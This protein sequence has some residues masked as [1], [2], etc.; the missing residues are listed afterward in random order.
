LQPLDRSNRQGVEVLDLGGHGFVLPR[1][2]RKPVRFVRRVVDGGVSLRPRSAIVLLL[3]AA[4]AGGGWW[5][6]ASGRAAPV[7]AQATSLAGLRIASVEVT[8][9]EEVSKI[10][11][12]ANMDLGP[13]RSLFS[14]DVH[15]VR[16]SLKRLAWVHDAKVTKSYPDRLLI[17]ISERQP[18]ALWQEDK[19]LWLVDRS[20]AVIAPFDDRF[21]G[22]P[23][24][25]GKGANEKGAEILVLARRHPRLLARI[26][27]FVRVGDRRWNL[28]I[29]DGPQILL[30]EGG[31]ALALERLDW[32][33]RE[34]QLLARDIT[35][36][37]MR[38][39]ERLV[40]GLNELAAKALDEAVEARAKAAKSRP[41]SLEKQ[42]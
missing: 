35:H 15:Q 9:N 25:V 8:G 31:E 22:L 40:I 38:S 23:L 6:S 18:V 2:A 19:Q 29:T 39:D 14:L 37:D 7:V 20:G 10:D 30:P 12:V 11:V 4:I 27:A 26:A 34:K 33:D 5:L 36:V 41:V 24:M 3:A 28:R 1:F 21:T 32:L 16:G 42:I 13:H 17:E